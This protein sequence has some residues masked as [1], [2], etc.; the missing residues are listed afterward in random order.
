MMPALATKAS[1]DS[2]PYCC[3]IAAAAERTLARDRRSA[4]TLANERGCTL[5]VGTCLPCG[6]SALVV[7]AGFRETAMTCAPPWSIALAVAAPIPLL[8]PVTSTTFPCTLLT[9]AAPLAANVDADG[10]LRL[11]DTAAAHGAAT[12]ALARPTVRQQAPHGE[13]SKALARPPTD[14]NAQKSITERHANPSEERMIAEN[15]GR[16]RPGKET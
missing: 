8:H 14:V 6:S 9:S 7:A 13:A 11:N 2:A 5:P 1:I 4:L 3:L 16:S 12:K 10:S 15:G